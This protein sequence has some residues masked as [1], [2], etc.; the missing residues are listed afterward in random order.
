MHTEQE[1]NQLQHN[2][3][4][5]TIYVMFHSVP[6]EH[7]GNHQDTFNLKGSKSAYELGTIWK[8]DWGQQRRHH[9][10]HTELISLSAGGGG[11]GGGGVKGHSFVQYT[12]KF[13]CT[14]D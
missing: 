4:V 3:A 5:P 6:A 8:R 1:N 14:T 12:K 11:G 13:V 7:R 2:L 9:N 10:M